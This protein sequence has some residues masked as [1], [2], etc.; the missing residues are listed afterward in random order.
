VQNELKLHFLHALQEVT[1][2]RSR[3]HSRGVEFG[4]LHSLQVPSHWVPMRPD[5]DHRLSDILVQN[6]DEYDGDLEGWQVCCAPSGV[7]AL[8][9][10]TVQPD[11][12]YWHV[13]GSFLRESTFS[14]PGLVMRCSVPYISMKLV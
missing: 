4:E 12:S 10:L 11:A 8:M 13:S 9:S 6:E 7:D 1:E 2:R 5:E 3:A 14:Q